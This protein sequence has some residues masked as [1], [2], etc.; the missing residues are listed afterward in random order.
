M[1]PIFSE[2][3]FE[4]LMLKIQEL[5][6][7]VERP[8]IDEE[9]KK[10]IREFGNLYDLE[11]ATLALLTDV[12]TSIYD[13]D[14]ATLLND[15]MKLRALAFELT[16]SSIDSAWPSK[17]QNYAD[18][19]LVDQKE[20]PNERLPGEFLEPLSF[21]KA[22]GERVSGRLTSMPGRGPSGQ[23]K[24]PYQDDENKRVDL[25]ALAKIIVDGFQLMSQ[26]PKNGQNYFAKIAMP[27]AGVPNI[28]NGAPRLENLINLFP[29]GNIDPRRVATAVNSLLDTP[30]HRKLKEY[31]L[32]KA[33]KNR[34]TVD[35]RVKTYFTFTGRDGGVESFERRRLGGGQKYADAVRHV[36]ELVSPELEYTKAGKVAN[37]PSQTTRDAITRSG[38]L[39][40][41]DSTPDFSTLPITGI[42]YP[43][44]APGPEG[45]GATQINWADDEEELDVPTKSFG[46]KTEK[47]VS[48]RKARIQNTTQAREMETPAVRF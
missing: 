35:P 21:D 13:Q 25:K 22:A 27:T 48:Q 42:M 47:R 6:S 12:L 3:A 2:I 5:K 4:V 46:E 11:P 28:G 17:N 38:L 7:F 29:I 23:T 39:T 44:P 24:G 40:L 20:A 33:G 8:D 37:Y 1:T 34:V 19:V 10:G 9:L 26:D 36:L 18:E 15:T 16:V 30:E 31:L 45:G 14:T 43:E 32:P 41:E